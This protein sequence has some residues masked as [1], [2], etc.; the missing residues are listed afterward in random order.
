M[1]GIYII[2]NSKND[3]VYV[4]QTND[5]EYRWMHHKSDLRGGIHHNRLLQEDWNIYGEDC[6]EFTVL[7]E[8]SI[9]ELDDRE[10]YWISYFDARS[11]VYNMDAGGYASKNGYVH[12]NNDLDK[13]RRVQNPEVVLQFS[14]TFDFVKRWIGGVTHI[15]KELGYTRACLSLRCDHTIK[16]MSQYKG[17]YWVYEKEYNHPDFSWEKYL[18]NISLLDKKQTI[19]SNQKR[20]LQYDMNLKLVNVWDSIKDIRNAGYCGHEV[21]SVINHSCGKRTCAGFIWC[22]DGYDFSDGYYDKVFKRIESQKCKPIQ[23]ID[24]NTNI[25]LKTFDTAIDAANYCNETPENFIQ[26]I[27]NKKTYHNYYWKIKQ[28]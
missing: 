4:G 26:S 24:R 2:K 18:E 23:Q 14:N 7:E 28:N 13:M 3:R 11:D 1:T 16:E 5:I 21:S 10:K 17:S 22:Y 19:K 12:T 20:I 25:V 27:M 8:C 9:S 6:F 15:S